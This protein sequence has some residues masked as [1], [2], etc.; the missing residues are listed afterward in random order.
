MLKKILTGVA[1]AM[2]VVGIGLLLFPT[3]SNFIGTQISNGEADKFDA[4]MESLED[5]TYESALKAGKIDADGYKIDKK[6]NRTSKSPVVFKGD[7]KRLYKDSV[8]YNEELKKNQYSMLR[9][10]TYSYA[11][12]NM[13]DY[14][15]DNGIYGYVTAESINMRLP[16]YLGANSANM[17]YGA[18][19]MAGTSLPIG[20]ESTN[21]VLAGHTGYIGRIFF[22][23]LRGLKIGDEVKFKNYWGTLK[24]RVKETKVNKPSESEDCYIQKGK[25]MLTM[26]TC[27]GN[28]NGGFDRYY[29][30]CERVK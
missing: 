20:G 5:G 13:N 22:D 12:L 21:A 30:I 18:A 24:Y 4:Q 1:V 2:L 9:N 10:D 8:A 23:N 27:I 7:L 25:D 11:A 28:G 3:V 19:H 26:F 29:V 6:G 14:G 16:V 15:I 17:S